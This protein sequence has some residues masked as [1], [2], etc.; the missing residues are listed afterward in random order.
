MVKNW[1]TQKA[2]CI[3]KKIKIVIYYKN[4]I[5]KLETV[6]DQLAKM[7][8]GIDF[9]GQVKQDMLAYLYFDGKKDGF[10]IDIGA[11]DGKTLSNTLIFENLGWQG[12]CVEPLPDVFEQLCKTRRCDCFN[13]A[14]ANTKSDSAEFVKASGVDML[15]GLN[16][17]MNEAHKKRIITEKG[18]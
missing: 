7:V 1:L 15:S 11:N 8:S 18:K 16:E 17:Q 12:I 4:R 13:A 5:H 14:I 2:K 10:Y 6:V 9:Q 3:L